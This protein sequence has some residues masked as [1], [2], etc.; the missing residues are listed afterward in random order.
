MGKAATFAICIVFSMTLSLAAW[1][2]P[3][4]E[5]RALYE[6]F[7][8]A[9]NARD[10]A[11]VRALLLPSPKLLWVSDGMSFWGP[12]AILARMASFQTIEIWQVEPDRARSSAIALDGRNAYLHLPLTLTIGTK[13]RPERFRFLVTMLAV[14]TPQGWRI[15][16]LLTTT[17]KPQQAG[18]S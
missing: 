4:D 3:E 14:E 15:A 18:A 17:E 2:S 11:S 10:L 12:D 9:Q 5:V 1:A 8:A 13:D 6:R 16:A 7:A